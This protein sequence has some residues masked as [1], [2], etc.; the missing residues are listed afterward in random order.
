MALAMFDLDNTLIA[1]DSD[2]LWGGFLAKIGVVDPMDHERE[3]QRFYQEYREG[4]L[5][6]NEFL[7]FSLRPLTQHPLKQL[8]AWRE[9]FL[10]DYI[11][12][13]ILTDGVALLQQHREQGNTLLI[14]TATNSFVTAPIAERLKVTHLLATEPEQHNGRYTGRVAGIPCFQQGKV[15]RVESWRLEHGES[16]HESYF[17]SD[18]HN[19]IPLLQWVE[20]PVAV[21]P[22]ASL[23]HYALAHNWP[24]I[25]L[26]TRHRG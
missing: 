18:S 22:D 25:S 12:P 2:Y 8:I 5:N 16:K 7:R 4:R 10:A 14:V 20:H 17:Y 3:N 21:D 13:I 23:C 6:I 1:G 15:E 9:R 26:R 19:D 24:I 11:D